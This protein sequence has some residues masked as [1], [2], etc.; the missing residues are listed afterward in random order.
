ML[1]AV[2]WARGKE[3][4]DT[5]ANEEIRKISDFETEEL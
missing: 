5:V 3:L 2:Y 4:T 1:M